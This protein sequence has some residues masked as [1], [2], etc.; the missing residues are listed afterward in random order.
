[1]NQEKLQHGVHL[2]FYC[3][4]RTKHDGMLLSE[5]LL[6]QARAHG[7]GGGSVFRAIAGFGRHGV[8]H[9]EQFFE[10]ADDLP[11]KIEFLLR[12]EQAEL[13]LQ[14]VRDAGVDATYAR[15]PASFAVLGGG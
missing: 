14:L 6:Q 3:H 7:L 13:L 11:V 15:S 5:W 12:E 4:S 1:M 8:L 9:E 2:T 10:L